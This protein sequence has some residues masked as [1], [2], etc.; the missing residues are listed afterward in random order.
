MNSWILLA[1]NRPL[2]RG[3][4]NEHPETA[5][6]YDNLASNLSGQD[7]LKE[8]EAF[9]RKALEIREHEL[10]KEHPD[11]ARSYNNLGGNLE[12]QGRLQDAKTLFSKAHQISEHAL[13]T[14]HRLTK[15][16]RKNRNRLD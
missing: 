6:S 12:R 1:S 7:Q 16:F 2:N 8:A 4:S 15:V 13:G 14:E 10:G 5:T 11:T 3:N 9:F